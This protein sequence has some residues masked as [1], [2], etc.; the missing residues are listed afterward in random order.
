MASRILFFALLSITSLTSFAQ[1][2]DTVFKKEWIEI[3]TLLVMRDLSKTALEKTNALYQKA[4]QRN[5]P[6]QV[7]KCLVYQYSLQDRI[8]PTDPNQ[9]FKTIQSEIRAATDE[10]EKSILYSILAKLYLQY[11]NN[12]RW[13]LYSRK[14]TANL[15]KEDIA[16][17]SSDDFINA[18]TKNFLLSVQHVSLL[19]QTKIE[20]YNTVIISGNSRTLRPT[21]F[22]LLAHEALDYF[23]AGDQYVTKPTNAFTIS[24]INTLSNLDTFINIPFATKD[25]AALQWKAL[26]LF[27]QLML[28]HK[29]DTGKNALIAVNLERIEWVYQNANFAGKEQ[30]YKNALEE[31]TTRY[32]STP[33]TAQAW[34]LLARLEAN[35][36]TGYQP[37]GDTTNRYG[38]VKAQQL[39]EKALSIY[40]GQSMGTVTLQNLLTEISRKELR[41]QTE[42]VNIPYQPFR[43]L[44]NYRNI[45][46]MYNRIIRLDNMSDL[47]VNWQNMEF[48]KLTAVKSY[49]SFTQVLPTVNDH[50]THGVEIK[51]EGL[52]VGEYALLSASTQN[53]NDSLGKLNVQFFS[54]S[55]I[56]YIKNRNDYFVLN[57]ETGKPLADA[58]VIILKQNYISRLQKTIEDT[59]A[60]R[61]TNRNGY[62]K[63]EPNTNNAGNYRYIFKY[64]EDKLNTGDYEY[65]YPDYNTQDENT[66]MEGQNSRVFFFT[67]RGIYRPGQ[68]VY[69]KGIGLIRSLKTNLSRLMT[70]KDSGWVYL[71]DINRKLIDSLPFNLNDY[72]S[73]SGKFQLPQNTLTGIFT[74]EQKKYSYS[75]A[76]FSVEE[77]KR[78]T[79]NVSF[80]KLTGAYRLNDSITITGNAKAYSGNVIDGAKVVYSV[81]RNTRLTNH[82]NSW[83]AFPPMNNREISHGEIQTSTDGS[84]RITFKALADDIADRND[85]P[86]SDFSISADVTDINGET[87]SSNTKVTVGYASMQLSVGVPLLSEADSLEKIFISSTN[88][89]NEKE[90]AVVHIRIYSLQSPDHPIRK[91]YWQ[92]PDQFVMSREEFNRNFPTDEYEEESNYQ[93]WQIAAL[94]TEGTIDTKENNSLPVPQSLLQPGYYR[95]EATTKD[96]Y[97]EDVKDIQYTQLFSTAKAQMPVPAYQ[98]NYTANGTVQPGKTATFISGTMANHLFVIR[99]TSKALNKP[100][101]Y[102]YIEKEKGF[103]TINYTPEEND[104]GGVIIS[105]AFVFDNRVYSFMYTVNVPWNNKVLQ[106]NYATYRN[107]TEPGS[108]ETWT[109]TIKNDHNEKAA[110][111]LLTSMYDASLDQFKPNNWPVPQLWPTNYSRDEFIGTNNFNAQNGRE[112][113]IPVKYITPFTLIN[114]RLATTGGELWDRDLVAWANDKTLVL[115]NSIRISLNGVGGLTS[116]G[117]GRQ[118]TIDRKMA[119]G[120]QGQVA[121]VKSLQSDQIDGNLY[122]KVIVRGSAAAV[123]AA[124]LYIVDGVKQSSVPN[125]DPTNIE[126]VRVLSAADAIALYGSEGQNG[127]IL[128]TTKGKNPSAPVQVRKNFNETAFFF[129]QLHADSSGNYRFSFTMPESNTEWKWMSLAHTKDLAFGTNTASIITQKKLMVQPNAPRFMREGDHMDFSTKIVNLSDKEITGQVSFELIDATTNTSIDGW[130]QNVFPSQYFT[131]EAGQSFG[132]KFPLQVPFSFNRPLTWRITA[133]AGEFSDGEENTLPVLTNRMLVTETVP[134]F[135]PKDS[136][137]HLVFDKLLHATSETLT[138][139]AVTVEYTSNPVWYAVQALPYLM[140]YPYEC[141]EQTFNRFY[142]NALAAYIVNKHPKIKQVFAQWKADSSSLKSNLQKNEE[143][144]QILLQETPWVLE[145]E[146]EEQQKKNISLLFDLVK[147]SSQ[148]ETLVQK[149]TQLQLPNGAFSWFKGGGEDRYMTNYILTGI[150]KL[151]RLGA[152]S[153]EIASGIRIMLVNALKYMDGQIAEDY[154]WLTKNAANLAERQISSSQI[155]YLYMRSFFRDISVASQKEYDYFF[156]QGKQFWV[157]QNSYYKAELG[158]IYYRSNEEKFAN[159]T[160]LPALLENAVNDPKKG[161]Y[162]NSAFT[163]A[164][165]QSPIEHQS[166]MIAFASELNQDKKNPSLTQSINAMKTWLLLNKQTNNWRTTI[167]TADACYALLLNGTDWLDAGKTVTIRLGKKLISSE[168]EKHEAGTGYFKKRIEGKQVN[169][170]M[171]NIT[172]SVKSTGSASNTVSQS[173]SW[174][175]IYWQYF[176]EMDKITPAATPLSLTKKL[177][178]E[179]NTGKGKLLEPVNENAELK[180]GDKIVVRIELRSDRDMD[181]L[182]LKDMRAAS[183]EPL[184]VLSGYKWQDGLGYYESTKDASTNFFISHLAKGTYIFDYP[185]FVTH[186]GIFSAGIATIQCMYAPEFSSH[187]E[188]IKVR[189]GN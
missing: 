139:E 85:N 140:E 56:S 28:V 19:L 110:A 96:K 177:F 95:V 52:P 147:L 82:W 55:N 145:A 73:F 122:E 188:G 130:F 69:F 72:G 17:W 21:L 39:A 105:E 29:N 10:A 32:A 137:V 8:L 45:D 57:R 135:L 24:D 155:D 40:T 178:I 25:S 175:N 134:L 70:T 152:L 68:V 92:R 165:Y 14:N 79:F 43:A 121:A 48:K 86:L 18:I 76:Y 4:K 113:Y 26:K 176:E 128:I 159:N 150:G 183:M 88:L 12:H 42:K 23:K 108:K 77:Y 158:L 101:G 93:T 2:T 164:W 181:Y 174:G 170:E 87:R 120:L 78:P 125:I 153:P 37:F 116:L 97:G 33:V 91:R 66:D 103:E 123:A 44:V 141:A 5:L 126:S 71:R 119:F 148:T 49:R 187:S 15:L 179:K 102:Q 38:Y 186:T 138:H 132:V 167:A 104:R 64:G 169:A 173:P 83:R 41:T 59:T 84:F 61:T 112:N 162:W 35:K 129:P 168:D 144:K 27:Q 99:K 53:F 51:I 127:A 133:R 143:L 89:S 7:I 189:V 80:E 163:N 115:P 58:K 111:E 146:S 67:D 34:Y 54:V 22:D 117:D 124:P 151:K 161:M 156:Q 172:I 180:T 46:T 157:K 31:I 65:N 98:F 36:A 100:S 62:F 118:L 90:N 166:M 60:I 94:V 114:D 6:A 74:I 171:G 13:N 63:F 182:H 11:Y 50:Q 184:N 185:L 47:G 9:V 131:I 109:V 20:A 106:V 1:Q 154:N 160:I 142:A 16:T 30:A 75:S 107:R 149:L 136:T 3:D 81:K